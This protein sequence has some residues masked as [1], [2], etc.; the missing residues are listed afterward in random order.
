MDQNAQETGDYDFID[1][2]AEAREDELGAV[3]GDPRR[4]SH[5]PHVKTS[6]DDGMFD[7]PCVE[8]EHAMNDEE[9]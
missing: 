1:S 4:C 2:A 5:H 9:E 6:S 7:V 3:Y 8:C